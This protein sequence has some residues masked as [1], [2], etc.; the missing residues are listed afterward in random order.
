MKAIWRGHVIASSD[1]TIEVYGYRYFP[2]ESVQMN[3][4]RGSPK[5]ADDKMCPNG[6]QFYD[7]ADGGEA[8]ERAAWSYELPSEE[9]LKPIGRWLGFWK[10][11][12]LEELGTQPSG[13]RSPPSTSPTGPRE[14]SPG[15]SCR[16]AAGGDRLPIRARPGKPTALA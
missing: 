2:R 15:T 5:T 8:S 1:K 12:K 11:V 6:V 13:R 7:L 10:D 16:S 9:G 4:L 14:S 3:F